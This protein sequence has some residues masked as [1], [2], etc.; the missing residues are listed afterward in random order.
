MNFGDNAYIYLRKKILNWE[1]FTD[2]NTAHFFIYCLLKANWESGSWK[3]IE[4]ER[5]E[6][7]ASLE[8]IVNETG[9]TVQNIR[10][11]IKHLISTQELTTKQHGK[12]RIFRVVKYDC[13]QQANTIPNNEVTRNQ[14]ES[15]KEV[16]TDNKVNKEKEVK[17]V[18][19][20]L[21]KDNS[22]NTF[23]FEETRSPYQ[24]LVNLWNE[25]SDYGIP[26]IT[27]IRGKRLVSLR[28]RLKEHGKDSFA[29]CVEQIKQSDFLRGKNF[30]FDI[31]WMLKETNYPKVLE[32]KY[33]N[34][35]GSR[36]QSSFDADS[37]MRR[38]EE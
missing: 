2:V 20:E 23:L 10:T 35:N 22:N 11:A 3:G 19:K 14:Q 5:G 28:A 24:D 8:T 38:F 1:W 13:Y 26:K 29:E 27:S 21:S 15:N 37:F 12:Y 31:D 4:F 6:F 9:L 7:I 25:L 30:N 16:T 18:N 34:K 32:G 33:S 36:S 17:E